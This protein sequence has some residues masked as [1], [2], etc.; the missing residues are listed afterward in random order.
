M[1]AV[2]GGGERQGW[3]V[4]VGIQAPN[5]LS[6]YDGRWTRPQLFS[7]QVTPKREACPSLERLGEIV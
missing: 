3:E 4:T 2:A 5:C 7:H 1:G 6:H